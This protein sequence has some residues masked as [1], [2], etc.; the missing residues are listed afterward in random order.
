MPEEQPKTGPY[1]HWRIERDDADLVWL[2]IDQAGSA[3][4]VLSSKVLKEL[5]AV[6][7]E[8]TARPPAGLI[9]LSNK[10]S[11]FIAGADV[12]EIA[13][14]ADGQAALALVQLGHATFDRIEALSFPTVAAIKGFCL[15]G[16]MELALALRHRVAVDDPGTRL[17]LP[18]VLLGI[19][20]GFGGTMRSIRLIGAPAA[21]D[22][23]LSGRTVDARAALRLG[24]VD[25]AVPERHFRSAAL[26]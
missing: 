4:N 3:T 6:L 21:M 5:G 14:I 7:D 13:A 20:P 24:L 1:Q 17:G 18:E 23:M 9:L 19:H 16:G 12:R 22:L 8:L 10:A 15:G 25:R 26:A 11:G 2:Y